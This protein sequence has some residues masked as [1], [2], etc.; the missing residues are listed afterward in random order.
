MFTNL[1]RGAVAGAAGTTALNAVTYLDMALRARPAS[2]MPQRAVDEIAKRA[3][4]PVPGE[5]EEHDNRLQGLGPLA[6]IAAGVGVGTVAGLLRP[7]VVRLPASVA[8]ILLGGA[9]MAGSDG[10]LAAVGLTDPRSWSAREW[11]TDLAP[12]LAYGA[13]TVAALHMASPRKAAASE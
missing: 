4:R 11:L 5:G 8:A 13:V 12:H 3:G 2:S 10:P 7:L 6:G 9:A 1:L